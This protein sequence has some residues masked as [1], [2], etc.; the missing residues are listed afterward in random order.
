M[1]E[2]KTLY[3][4]K[5]RFSWP[6]L[7]SDVADWIKKCAHCMLTNRWRRRGQEL[8]FSWPVSSPFTI[9]HVD[10]W[11]LGHHTNPKGYMALMNIMCEMSQFLVVVPV[12]NE[13]S[14][15]LA[16]FSCSMSL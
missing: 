1:G 7:R 10:L 8:T 9:L 6:R 12:P 2:Y 16:Y 4:I 11:M 5:L 14:A 13:S 3:R 15:T